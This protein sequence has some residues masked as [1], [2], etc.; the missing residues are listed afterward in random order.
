MR[1]SGKSGSGLL[2][3]QVVLVDLVLLFPIISSDSC[4]GTVLTGLAGKESRRS[5][6]GG[7]FVGV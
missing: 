2:G 1:A 6:S 3:S 5:V 4:G 7:A